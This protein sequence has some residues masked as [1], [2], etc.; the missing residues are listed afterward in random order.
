LEIT[1]P[2]TCEEGA[3]LPLPPFLTTVGSSGGCI[4]LLLSAMHRGVVSHTHSTAGG[5][6]PLS[7]GVALSHKPPS[8]S[9]KRAF[10]CCDVYATRRATIV[11]RCWCRRDAKHTP[12]ACL[13]GRDRLRGELGRVGAT[14]GGVDARWVYTMR[15]AGGRGARCS[16]GCEVELIE[17][18]REMAAWWGVGG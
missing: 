3:W 10:S 12:G 17:T 7:A 14:C 5:H 2:H 11:R 1:H 6:A 18:L 4:A 13:G 8:R 16:R 9:L 15:V